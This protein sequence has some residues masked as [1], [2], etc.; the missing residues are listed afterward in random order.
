MLK[1]NFL[2]TK[3]SDEKYMCLQD[4]KGTVLSCGF[5]PGDYTEKQILEYYEAGILK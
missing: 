2:P 3:D 1:V 4:E 5:V